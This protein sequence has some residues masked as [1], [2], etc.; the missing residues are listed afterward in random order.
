MR[1]GLTEAKS[2]AAALRDITRPSHERDI[3]TENLRAGV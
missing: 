2:D 1:G 3:V